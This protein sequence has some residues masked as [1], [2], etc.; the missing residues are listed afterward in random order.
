[1][2]VLRQRR[3]H[4]RATGCPQSLGDKPTGIGLP[5]PGSR[6]LMRVLCVGCNATHVFSTLDPD[7]GVQVDAWLSRCS[8]GHQ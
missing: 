1:M 8:E 5:V 7:L 2:A 4:N 6:V 3:T